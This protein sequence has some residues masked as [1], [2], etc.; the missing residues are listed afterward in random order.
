M[1]YQNARWRHLLRKVLVA[2][3]I[4]APPAMTIKILDRHPEPQELRPGQMIVMVSDGKPK[5]A[6]FKCPG[7]CGGH[8]Q[9]SLDLLH[10]PR[11]S[12]RA[13]FLARPTISPAVFRHRGCGAHFALRHGQIDWL[14]STGPEGVRAG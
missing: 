11:W 2:G 10:R 1:R 3:R 4:I 6:Y 9:L 14:D 7:N 8:V 12:V 13:D 5:Y